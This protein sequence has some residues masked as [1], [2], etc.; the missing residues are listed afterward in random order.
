MRVPAAASTLHSKNRKEKPIWN[1][2]QKLKM[3]FS[4]ISAILA[5]TAAAIAKPLPAEEPKGRLVQVTPDSSFVNTTSEDSSL[6]VFHTQHGFGG[7]VLIP[8][9]SKRGVNVIAY[10]YNSACQGYNYEWFNTGGGCYEVCFPFS[11]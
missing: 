1:L 7:S 10:P 9:S 11:F 5:F 3:K 2:P 8:D 6:Y 4:T